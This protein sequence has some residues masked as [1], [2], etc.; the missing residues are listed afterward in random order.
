MLWLTRLLLASSLLASPALCGSFLV[1]MPNAMRSMYIQFLP[2]VRELAGRGHQVTLVHGS[3]LAGNITG[4]TEIVHKS[5]TGDY[6]AFA[7]NTASSATSSRP[8]RSPTLAL[9]ICSMSTA[10]A[11]SPISA[12]PRT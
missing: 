1:Y 12:P 9:V 2:L 5:Y 7:S 8:P 6:E 3:R 10:P 4:V 11:M